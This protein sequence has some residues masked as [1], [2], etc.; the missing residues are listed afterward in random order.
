MYVNR[1]TLR[2]GP[3]SHGCRLF[4]SHHSIIKVDDDGSQICVTFAGYEYEKRLQMFDY[5]TCYPTLGT[6]VCPEP[7]PNYYVDDMIVSYPAAGNGEGEPLVVLT[8]TAVLRFGLALIVLIA[9][10]ATV[11]FLDRNKKRKRLANDDYTMLP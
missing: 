3:Y 2:S 9:L 6:G 4:P 11:F 5:S 7:F 10:G 1:W 8:R